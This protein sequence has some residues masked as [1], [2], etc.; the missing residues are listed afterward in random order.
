MVR[1]FEFID[2]DFDS[3]MSDLY[4]QTPAESGGGIEMPRSLGLASGKQF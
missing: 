2:L 3:K 1:R 4:L